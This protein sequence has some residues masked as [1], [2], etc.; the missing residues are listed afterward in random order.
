LNATSYSS[1]LTAETT[2]DFGRESTSAV[3][4][5]NPDKFPVSAFHLQPYRSARAARP[6]GRGSGELER[7]VCLPLLFKGASFDAMNSDTR[8]QLTAVS[9]QARA[10]L[11]EELG[12]GE[13]GV[14]L[15]AS[16]P[17]TNRAHVSETPAAGNEAGSRTEKSPRLDELA[18]EAAS[19]TACDLHRGRNRS[20]FHRGSPDADLVFVGEG[21]GYEE[22]RQG[23]PF[24]G[25]AGQLLD[26]M[27][28]AMGYDRDAVYICNVVKCRPP[29]NRTPTP[30]E[31][32]ACGRFLTAQLD[33]VSPKAIVA[34]GSC[35]AEALGVASQ[36]RSWRGRWST[37]RGIPVMPTYHP[38]FLL[39][40]PK[41]KGAVWED[42]QAVLRR[43]GK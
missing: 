15:P 30:A 11:E 32:A 42:L 29:G 24:V 21:P 41:F 36:T 9:A 37:W 12:L 2:S 33:L 22:D 7:R 38:A 25:P 1:E 16:A 26:R 19:C 43:L 23:L 6:N 14:Y 35:A 10:H 28:A 18:R 20:V 17:I 13:T 40:T 27:V 5:F 39:R 3:P 34:L 4:G 31:A 8:E